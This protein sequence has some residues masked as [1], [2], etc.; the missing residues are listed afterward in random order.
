MEN[1][2]NVKIN[3]KEYIKQYAKDFYGN[4]ELIKIS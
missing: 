4:K 2:V 3:G 1:M